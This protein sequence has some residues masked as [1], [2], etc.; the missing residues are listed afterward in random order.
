MRTHDGRSDPFYRTALWLRTRA[1]H[2]AIEPLC[3]TCKSMHRVTAGREVDHITPIEQ[4]GDRTADAN[5]QTLCSPCH[6]DKTAREQGKRVR[7]GCDA[8]GRP[9]DATHAWNT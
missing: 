3:R 6:R 4:G 7:M 5:L 8:Q 2:L 1:A 9:L